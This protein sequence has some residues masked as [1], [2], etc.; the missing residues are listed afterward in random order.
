[1]KKKKQTPPGVKKNRTHYISDYLTVRPLATFSKANKKYN[2]LM[3]YFGMET[4]EPLS[5]TKSEPLSRPIMRLGFAWVDG[6]VDYHTVMTFDESL[7]SIIAKQLAKKNIPPAAVGNIGVTLVSSKNADVHITNLKQTIAQLGVEDNDIL[8]LV[9]GSGSV[10]TLV[11]KN[12]PADADTEDKIP[13]EFIPVAFHPFH[14]LIICK[15]KF[16]NSFIAYNIS[17]KEE[18]RDIL[19][20]VDKEDNSVFDDIFFDNRFIMYIRKQRK[21]IMINTENPNP[22]QWTLVTSIESSN[23]IVNV[24]VTQSGNYLI[25]SPLGNNVEVYQRGIEGNYNIIKSLPEKQMYNMSA[26]D[27]DNGVLIS[28]DKSVFEVTTVDGQIQVVDHRDVY[29]VGDRHKHQHKTKLTSTLLITDN[30]I[31]AKIYKYTSNEGKLTF[32]HLCTIPFGQN[33]RIIRMD[34]SDN[35][36]TLCLTVRESISNQKRLYFV[37]LNRIHLPSTEL[38]SYQIWYLNQLT[39]NDIDITPDRFFTKIL[40]YDRI[41]RNYTIISPSMTDVEEPV[42]TNDIPVDTVLKYVHETN[43]HELDEV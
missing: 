19:P 29:K 43:R 13:S 6:Y 11:L 16:T 36:E 27:I 30:H 25:I 40:K 4:Y 10:P 24:T 32:T 20:D 28:G 8:Q 23:V 9:V 41:L 2:A 38:P 33:N 39:K 31:E 3:S 26:V 1:M 35:E 14:D 18:I 22:T 42:H 5:E 17:T 34:I 37:T 12:I 7:Q 15:T 21:I